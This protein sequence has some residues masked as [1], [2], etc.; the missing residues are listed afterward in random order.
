MLHEQTAR[1]EFPCLR[2]SRATNF[3]I[4]LDG[5]LYP[6]QANSLIRPSF[7][8]VTELLEFVGEEKRGTLGYVESLSAA[9]GTLQFRLDEAD[10]EISSLQE[11]VRILMESASDRDRLL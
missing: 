2:E 11:Q 10:I 3:D 6:R 8:T 7:R 5:S 1:S 4:W 9:D